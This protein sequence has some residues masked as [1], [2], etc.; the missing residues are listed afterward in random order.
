MPIP[1]AAKPPIDVLLSDYERR[2]S[3]LEA[4]VQS[5]P[6]GAEEN[7]TARSRRPSGD[8]Q[9]LPARQVWE[10]YGIT[11]MT[12]HRWLADTRMGFPRPV[13]LGRLRYW[14]LGDLEAWEHGRAAGQPGEA[15]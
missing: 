12:L 5:L 3:S 13:Y 4:V 2:L 1:T 7:A 9:F 6:G 11:S 10:R 15:K 14:R 8:E